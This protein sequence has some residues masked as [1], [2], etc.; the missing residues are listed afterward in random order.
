VSKAQ[1]TA[2]QAILNLKREDVPYWLGSN[3]TLKISHYEK[4][5][6]EETADDFI[7]H[8]SVIN[9][10]TLTTVRSAEHRIPGRAVFTA[11]MK[12]GSLVDLILDAREELIRNLE[13]D[14]DEDLVTL[15]F[16]AWCDPDSMGVLIDAGLERGAF[17]PIKTG[18]G[19]R[20]DTRTLEE[21][22]RDYRSD[23]E[24]KAKDWSRPYVER[25]F[26]DYW[27]AKRWPVNDDDPPKTRGLDSF[28]AMRTQAIANMAQAGLINQ[29]QMQQYIDRDLQAQADR[30]AYEQSRMA[31]ANQTS[32][33]ED[34]ANYRNW[35]VREKK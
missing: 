27:S 8:G 3:E 12:D 17:T 31:Q 19:K 30:M 20:A 34:M 5:R 15:M 35:L 25:L 10:Q 6:L 23:L 29:A 22:E 9:T 28:V 11:A 7:L 14:W 16:A 4:M 21:K 13:P 2:I 24:K 33:G 26:R 1:S 18:I 32:L